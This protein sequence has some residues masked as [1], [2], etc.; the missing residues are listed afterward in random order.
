MSDKIK[1]PTW[2][3]VNTPKSIVEWIKQSYRPTDMFNYLIFSKIFHYV[4]KIQYC[5]ECGSCNRVK[6]TSRAY[7]EYLH[8]D[9]CNADST[10]LKFSV[11]WNMGKDQVAQYSSNESVLPSIIKVMS[12]AYYAYFNETPP[13]NFLNTNWSINRGEDVFNL[14]KHLEPQNEYEEEELNPFLDNPFVKVSNPLPP[15]PNP[16]DTP[17]FSAKF[18]G[19]EESVGINQHFTVCKAAL[20]CPFIWDDTFDWDLMFKRNKASQSHIIP[21]LHMWTRFSSSPRR[22]PLHPQS[23]TVAK[24]KMKTNGVAFENTIVNQLAFANVIKKYIE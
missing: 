9:H 19:G 6:R 20:L 2:H 4:P 11:Q 1:Y 8:C 12:D 13:V 18:F 5:F 14:R 15:Q 17:V 23:F 21:L 3:D 16:N 24:P 10:A 22:A 7:E